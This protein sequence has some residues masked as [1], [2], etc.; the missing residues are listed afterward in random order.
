MWFVGAHALWGASGPG[1]DLRAQTAAGRQVGCGHRLW[2]GLEQRVGVVIL[3]IQCLFQHQYVERVGV[4]GAG[5]LGGGADD[6]VGEGEVHGAFPGNGSA[7]YRQP[8]RRAEALLHLF[9]TPGGAPL[10]EVVDALA[11]RMG[12]VGGQP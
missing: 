2:Q 9:L 12:L 3:L 10:R 6:G 8:R 11:Q 7:H 4:F 5:H 1:V